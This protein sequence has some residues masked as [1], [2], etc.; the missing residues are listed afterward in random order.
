MMPTL[1]P[2]EHTPRLYDGSSPEE[3]LG[4]RK[5][6]VNLGGFH[7]YKVPVCIVEG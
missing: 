4:M 3:I 2:F 7:C 6:F 5:E 1:P